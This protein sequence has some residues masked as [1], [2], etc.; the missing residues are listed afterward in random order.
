M[1]IVDARLAVEDVIELVN[2]SHGALA[3]YG[4]VFIEARDL[5]TRQWMLEEPIY[6]TDEERK[7][8]QVDEEQLESCKRALKPAQSVASNVTRDVLTEIM[9]E[10]GLRDAISHATVPNLVG[11]LTGAPRPIRAVHH[12]LQSSGIHSIATC[13]GGDIAI[14]SHSPMDM[15]NA[16][17]SLTRHIAAR[18]VFF[19]SLGCDQP[20][21]H[22]NQQAGQLLVFVRGVPVS[23]VAHVAELACARQ[24]RLDLI[25]KD[26]AA[27]YELRD[28]IQNTS[29]L[30]IQQSIRELQSRR[31]AASKVISQAVTSNLA[32][33]KARLWHPCGRLA[34]R[35]VDT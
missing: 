16:I 30:D 8:L 3:R 4:E 34:Q 19:V 17:S 27:A 2:K 14:V 1:T 7:A 11:L 25:G 13:A 23:H 18:V 21:V 6:F 28:I 5:E 31:E 12:D 26:F 24:Y 15:T 32:T 10:I 9:R 22:I 29:S 35:M 20:N 33:I